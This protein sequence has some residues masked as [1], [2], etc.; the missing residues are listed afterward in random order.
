MLSRNS[1]PSPENC[2]AIAVIS[3]KVPFYQMFTLALIF[4]INGRSGLFAAELALIAAA[5]TS[6]H[7]NAPDNN[8]GGNGFVSAGSNGALSPARGLFH[9][10]LAGIPSGSTI[11][12]V[13]LRLSVTGLPFSSAADS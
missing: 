12:N 13:Q 2:I 3:R 6:V 11:V 10:D 7:E 9:F 5:D 1:F 8:M 4:L